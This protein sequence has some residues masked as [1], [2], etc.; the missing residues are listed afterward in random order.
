LRRTTSRLANF[1]GRGEDRR[2]EERRGEER[3]NRK[4]RSSEGRMGGWVDG[5]MGGRTF[6]LLS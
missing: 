4:I 5:R 2:G 3:R 6:H 1:T